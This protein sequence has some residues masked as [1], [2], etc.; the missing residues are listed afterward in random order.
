MRVWTSS[1]IRF[2][3]PENKLKT[4]F[5]RKKR[6]GKQEVAQRICR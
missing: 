1:W 6:I 2:L 4:E 3:C 5:L